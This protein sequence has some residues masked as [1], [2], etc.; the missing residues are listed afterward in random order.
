MGSTLINQKK[1]QRS[2][3]KFKLIG[4]ITLIIIFMSAQI[5]FMVYNSLKYNNQ[6]EKIIDNINMTNQISEKVANV[7]TELVNVM[8][9][10]KKK[11]Q[12][13]YRQTVNEIRED[14]KL[15]LKSDTTNQSKI[16]I[17]QILKLMDAIDENVNAIEDSLKQNIRII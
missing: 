5:F 3:I 11:E 10:S 4:I 9:G 6:Y 7:N 16:E 1:L 2:K 12:A 17:I 8:F 14:A 15:I 13:T